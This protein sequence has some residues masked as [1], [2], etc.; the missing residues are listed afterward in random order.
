ML[1][2]KT[3]DIL[4]ASENIIAHQ[5]NTWGSFGGGL[6][7][8]VAT[9]YP[10]VEQEYKIF[11]KSFKNNLIGQYQ[12]VSIGEHK[13]IVN[14]FSQRNFNTDYKALKQIFMGLL[15]SCKLSKMTIAVPYGMG[16]GIANGYWKDVENIL[17][18]LSKEYEVDISVYKLEE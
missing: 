16:C 3:G 17:K 18:I 7:L 14:C 4:K 12:A 13:Y 1:I 8:Q 9:Q 6:A 15:E 11:C 2:Y 10:N 5:C